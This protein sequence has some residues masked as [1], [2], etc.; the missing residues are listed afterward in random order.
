MASSSAAPASD[1]PALPSIGGYCANCVKAFVR[2]GTPSGELTTLKVELAGK[3][4]ALP[5]YVKRS[6]E[7][8][9]PTIL[10]VTDVFGHSFKNNQVLADEYAARGFNVVMPDILDGRAVDGAST[11]PVMDVEKAGFFTSVGTICSVIPTFVSFLYNNGSRKT[12][13]PRVEAAARA[14]RKLAAELGNGKMGSVGFC[15][16]G[17]YAVLLARAGLSDAFVGVHPS[18]LGVPADLEGL[19]GKPGLFCLS[20]HD[21]MITR[22][23][24]DKMTAA[25]PSADHIWYLGVSH[26]FAVRGPPSADAMR[27]KCAADVTA[28]FKKALA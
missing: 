17:P 15:F 7:P 1:K 12:V 20:E 26:G 9:S 28:F 3:E 19:D 16:G 6:A 14:A 5:C 25:L 22:S 23:V 24:A 18:G 27:E 2:D 21:H 10:F 8:N 13:Q 11:A 4:V